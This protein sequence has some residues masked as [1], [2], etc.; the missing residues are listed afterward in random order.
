MRYNRF[1]IT[2]VLIKLL[3]YLIWYLVIG[4][5]STV[6]SPM[7]GFRHAYPTFFLSCFTCQSVFVSRCSVSPITLLFFAIRRSS[8]FLNFCQTDLSLC[9]FWPQLSKAVLWP[10]LSF[11]LSVFH[12][13]Y[14][15]ISRVCVC[16]YLGSIF[17]S[18]CNWQV[19]TT[20]PPLTH[21]LFLL[22]FVCVCVGISL[23]LQPLSSF[24]LY[25]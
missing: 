10:F 24:S 2:R 17:G 6:Q 15:Q 16:V 4:A 23:P 13:F 7:I 22:E 9:L 8:S 14:R 21:T 18:V 25:I 11:V 19:W 1:L 20:Q 3:F 5:M 12:F